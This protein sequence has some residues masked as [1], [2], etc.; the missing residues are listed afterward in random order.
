MWRGSELLGA[1]SDQQWSDAFRAGG[2][3]PAVADR[4]IGRLR[5]K[6]ADGRRLGDADSSQYAA[7]PPAA[8]VPR[9]TIGARR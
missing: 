3:D 6:I 1:L 5:Q 7:A 2:Y 4:F 9:L 8:P